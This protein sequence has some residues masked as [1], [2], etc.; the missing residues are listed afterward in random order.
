ML[1]VALAQAAESGEL[2]LLDGGLCRF[3]KR[4]DGQVT[5][6]ELLVLPAARRRGLGKK[7]VGLASIGANRVVARCPAKYDSNAFWKKIGF[8]LEEGKDGVNT[9]VKP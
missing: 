3:Y 6:R 7:L 2:L 5:I 8:R 4:R 9:W 1:F